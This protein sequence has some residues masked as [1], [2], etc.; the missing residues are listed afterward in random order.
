[1]NCRTICIGDVHA[2]RDELADL[3]DKLQITSSDSIYFVGD[4]SDKGPN[5]K[6]CLDIVLSLPNACSCRGNHDD[7]FRRFQYHETRRK[8]KGIANPM[9]SVCPE[10]VEQY[11][12]LDEVQSA[13]LANLP[14]SIDIPKHNAI[15]VHG[16]LL[17]GKSI[18]TQIN[19]HAGEVMRLRYVNED[20]DFVG[21]MNGPDQPANT[22]LWSEV[23]DG[24]CNVIYGHISHSLE[25]PRID[26]RADG[27]ECIGLDTGCVT[28]GRLT[29][30]ILET[31]E[32]VQVQARK[33]YAEPW[34]L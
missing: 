15:V 28:G 3:L 30:Y 25:Q 6:G 11:N 32:I 14:V 34:K 9:T 8:Q 12:Q 26:K 1:M 18:K 23:Y 17:P 16:G 7:K 13:W 4:L 29:A 31:K 5:L 27:I 33:K 24:P 10:D 22:L 21:L 19:K 2:C 20:G